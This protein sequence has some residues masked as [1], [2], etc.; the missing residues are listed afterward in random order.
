MKQIYLKKKMVLIKYELDWSSESCE[1]VLFLF[2]VN[3]TL[4]KIKQ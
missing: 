3:T 4:Y 1:G 2:G